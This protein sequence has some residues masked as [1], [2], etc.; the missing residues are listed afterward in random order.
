[1]SDTVLDA[2]DTAAYETVSLRSMRLE[3]INNKQLTRL[4][5]KIAFPSKEYH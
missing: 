4:S 5:D 3:E 1:M 2:E